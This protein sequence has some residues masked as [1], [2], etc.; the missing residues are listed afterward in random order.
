MSVATMS[1][2]S[3]RPLP[4]GLTTDGIFDMMAAGQCSVAEAKA[5]RAELEARKFEFDHSD[6]GC[7]MIRCQSRGRFPL[8]SAYVS[9][10]E[11]TLLAPGFIESL[12]AYVEAN[13]AELVRL[14]EAER[15]RKKAEKE[16][17]KQKS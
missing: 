2:T 8:A 6:K 16:A 17:A 3:I 13:R 15:A 1:P 14:S 7:V 5:W 4:A 12:K 11:E 9:E 10:L